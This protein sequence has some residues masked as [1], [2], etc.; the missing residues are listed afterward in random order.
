MLLPD[1]IHPELSIYY[2]GSLVL[3]ELKEKERQSFFD[4]YH[5][6]KNNSDMSLPTFILTLDWLYLIELAQIDNEGWVQLCS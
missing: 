1:N 5:K 4:L 6:L 3:Q 2:N